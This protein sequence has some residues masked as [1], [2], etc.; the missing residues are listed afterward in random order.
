[1]RG[2]QRRSRWWGGIASPRDEA[3]LA[4][5]EGFEPTY[6]VPSAARFDEGAWRRGVGA[7][8]CRPFSARRVSTSLAEREGFEP[9]RRYKPPTRLAGERLRPLGHLSILTRADLGSRRGCP[10]STSSKRTSSGG[11]GIRT[12]GTP[13]GPAVFKTAAF[14]RSAIPPFS[15]HVP[16]RR[17]DCTHRRSPRIFI[18]APRRSP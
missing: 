11:S 9:S 14:V 18:A 17:R 5:R 13:K 6:V 3:A 10:G 15:P 1:M 4:E 16:T 7:G 8:G 12:H 2:S